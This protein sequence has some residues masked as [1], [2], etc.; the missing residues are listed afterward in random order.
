MSTQVL[1]N[2]LNAADMFTPPESV[3]DSSR[4]DTDWSNLQIIDADTLSILKFYNFLISILEQL[5]WQMLFYVM[6]GIFQLFLKTT[7]DKFIVIIHK[8][9][10]LLHKTFIL[11]LEYHLL[12]WFLQIYYP[13]RCLNIV[14]PTDNLTLEHCDNLCLWPWTYTLDPRILH[15]CFNFRIL[16]QYL[17]MILILF[18][19]CFHI[20][21]TVMF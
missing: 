6:S 17:L 13:H 4:T 9:F 11:M 21:I 3:C 1:L 5:I 12:M 18:Y 2:F 7:S 8:L 20:S 16:S 19:L 15:S 10:N 14:Y